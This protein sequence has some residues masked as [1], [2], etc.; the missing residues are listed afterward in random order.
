MMPATAGKLH[1]K[2]RGH[3]GH[4]EKSHKREARGSLI[5][6]RSPLENFDD[7]DK[8]KSISAPE[9]SLDDEKPPAQDSNKSASDTVIL[10]SHDGPKE[11]AHS[12]KKRHRHGSRSSRPSSHHGELYTMLDEEAGKTAKSPKKGKEKEKKGD[13]EGALI[14]HAKKKKAKKGRTMSGLSTSHNSDG[15]A[16]LRNRRMTLELSKLG[17]NNNRPQVGPAL[18]RE[19]KMFPCLLGFTLLTFE[20]PVELADQTRVLFLRYF[21]EFIEKEDI[22]VYYG[23]DITPEDYP[24]FDQYLGML[25]SDWSSETARDIVLRNQKTRTKERVLKHVRFELPSQSDIYSY[26]TPDR[27]QLPYPGPSPVSIN[28]PALSSSSPS[29]SSSSTPPASSSSSSSLALP[30][31][32]S[33]EELTTPDRRKLPYPST[34]PAAPSSPATEAANALQE[35]RR[36]VLEEFEKEQEEYEEMIVE[37]EMDGGL[38]FVDPDKFDVGEWLK[39]LNMQRYAGTFARHGFDSLASVQ[40]LM[41]EDL[42]TLGVR[43][44]R[45]RVLLM[46]ESQLL[47]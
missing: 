2:D 29:S 5:L 38:L 18:K 35:K 32:G 12:K 36:K 40:M 31:S 45:H 46:K 27:S 10:S 17:A 11:K 21:K 3:H 20:C 19:K 28:S 26:P 41:E 24:T 7:G 44:P 14:V 43:V 4:K 15:E 23:K 1:K 34:E 47:V 37:W 13:S 39:D 16:N 22:S 9:L 42:D 30:S 25:L 33:T 6:P 8:D